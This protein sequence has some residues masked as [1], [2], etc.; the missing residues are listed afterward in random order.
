MKKIILTALTVLMIFGLV[1]CSGDLHDKGLVDGWGV[2]VWY[3]TGSDWSNSEWKAL[4]KVSS[5]EWTAELTTTG[6]IDTVRFAITPVNGDWSARYEPNA[7]KGDF[8]TATGNQIILQT[9]E[10]AARSSFAGVAGKK[11]KLTLVQNPD[12]FQLYASVKAL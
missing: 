10:P 4:T 5:T 2:M 9:T 1:G 8:D 7:E 11:Y 12:D 3:N 6:A